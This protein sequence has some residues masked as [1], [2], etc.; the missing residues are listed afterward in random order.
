MMPRDDSESDESICTPAPLVDFTGTHGGELAQVSAEDD[1]QTSEGFVQT[2]R[3]LAQTAIDGSQLIGRHH[4]ELVDDD[5][6]DSAERDSKRVE[7]AGTETSVSHDADASHLPVAG[8]PHE[9]EG[10][11]N[12]S[13]PNR[14]RCLAR[15]GTDDVRVVR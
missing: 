8:T 12:G 4:A 3:D 14:N 6:L 13:S 5:T 1:A 7:I 2:L 9:L 11:V 15:A 10:G